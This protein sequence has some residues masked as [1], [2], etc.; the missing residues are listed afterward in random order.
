MQ[1]REI[2]GFFRP[3]EE[4]GEFSN[5]F[6]R[7]FKI[8][9][10]TFNSVEQYMMY[11]KAKTFNDT[12]AALLIME[13]SNQKEIKAL[14]RSVKNYKDKEWNEI[15]QSVV[16]EALL[17]K[18]TQ[19]SDLQEVLLSTGEAELVEASPYDRV[20]GIG[21]ANTPLI[22]DK[23]SWRGKNLLGKSLMQVRDLIKQS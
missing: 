22:Q 14:G 3:Y 17:A 19:H 7:D 2:I 15:R 8:G 4:Y 9:G 21:I 5:W 6:I 11:I 13:S 10:V 23:R 16:Q 1:R 12:E 20:W 18:F